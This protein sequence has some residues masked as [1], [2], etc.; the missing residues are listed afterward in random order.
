MAPDRDDDDTEVRSRIE[1][2]AERQLRARREG[3]HGLWF[4][5]GM[6]GMVGWSVAVPTLIGVAIGWWLDE[7]A[8]QRF[9]W[10]LALLLAGVTV[11]AI[12]AWYWVNR[13]S[14]HE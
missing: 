7:V 12:N 5:L 9:S 3:R 2:Q 13:E 1:K 4:G 10:T 14:G 8:P 11:G 6:F